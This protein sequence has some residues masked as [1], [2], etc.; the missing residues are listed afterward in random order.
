MA[1]PP[2]IKGATQC[3][4]MLS[5]MSLLQSGRVHLGF[6]GAA[7]VDRFGNLNSTEVRG[8]KGD[9]VASGYVQPQEGVAG[10][11]WDVPEGTPG[12]EYA[13]KVS[14]PF[15][16]HVPGERKFD[17]RSYRAPRLKSQIVFLR[18]GYGPGDEV[19]A[20]MH[21]ER[22]EGGIPAGATVTATARVD[23]AEAYRGQAQVDPAGNVTVRFKLPPAI[24]PLTS[25]P[26][27]SEPPS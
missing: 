27:S 20:T 4:D 1:D 16:G 23:G 6:L 25:G 11:A 14:H 5:V 26:R 10:F 12:G 9:I 8:P 18:D 13:V 2:N 19:S 15:S 24:D 3:L 21:V 7:E 17:V 22:A